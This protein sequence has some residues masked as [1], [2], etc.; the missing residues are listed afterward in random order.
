MIKRWN[1]KKLHYLTVIK[2]DGDRKK[3]LNVLS[4]QQVVGKHISLSLKKGALKNIFIQ[5]AEERPDKFKV[6]REKI[7]HVLDTNKRDITFSGNG[8][9]PWAFL[10]GN[11][12]LRKKIQLLL[13]GPRIWG[14]EMDMGMKM[15]SN[16][17][18]L[19]NERLIN[20]LKN[21]VSSMINSPDK[22]ESV[23]FFFRL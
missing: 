6:V 11:K 16:V 4:L 18:K 2:K 13:I 21:Q 12:G 22:W 8:R 20:F 3:E 7:F 23:E 1:N 15:R 9:C 5:K 17:D 19:G 10:V 14:I